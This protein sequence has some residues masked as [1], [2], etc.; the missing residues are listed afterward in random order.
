MDRPA[1]GVGVFIWKNGK[2]LLGQRKN[3]RGAGT[4]SVPGGHM[5][6]GESFE[7]TVKRETMEE[8]GIRIGNIRKL[9]FSNDIFEKDRKHY[10]TLFFAADYVSGKVRNMEPDKCEGWEWHTAATAPRPLF[11]PLENLLGQMS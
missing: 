11:T 1:V 10:V 2:F 9:T 6:G 8:V 3:V 4:W 5:E 7:Q